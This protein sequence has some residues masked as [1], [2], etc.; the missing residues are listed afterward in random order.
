[1]RRSQSQ[2][3]VEVG[4]KLLRRD[5]STRGLERQSSVASRHTPDRSGKRQWSETVTEPTR[6]PRQPRSQSGSQS[7][8]ATN[9][10]GV[11]Q[12]AA[13]AANALRREQRWSTLQARPTPEDGHADRRRLR[14][15]ETERQSPGRPSLRTGSPASTSRPANRRRSVSF[16]PNR[17]DTNAEENT[18]DSDYS[19]G[20]Y[21]SMSEDNTMSYW[22]RK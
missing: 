7:P 6:R 13:N 4:E 12:R 18:A 9:R 17:G 15:R 3:I 14:D 8:T 20:D 19:D 16:E 22:E 10:S 1:M 2:V 5:Y 21:H 11:D